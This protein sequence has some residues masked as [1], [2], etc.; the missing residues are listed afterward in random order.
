MFSY[1]HSLFLSVI[2][3]ERNHDLGR[4]QFLS[5]ILMRQNPNKLG[6]IPFYR[7]TEAGLQPLDFLL[8]LLSLRRSSFKNQTSN[9]KSNT[10]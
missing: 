4:G 5:F 10:P 8:S 1:E 3:A 2:V 7:K 6:F 9:A